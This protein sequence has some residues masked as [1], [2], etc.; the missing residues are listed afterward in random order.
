MSR[1]EKVMDFVENITGM[2]K[3]EYLC[4]PKKKI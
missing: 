4:L 3:S 2:T 1:A